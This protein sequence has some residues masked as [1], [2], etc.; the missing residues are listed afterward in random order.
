[1]E[2]VTQPSA[3]P[4]EGWLTVVKTSRARQKIQ[5][6]LK[7]QRREDSIALGRDMLVREL[8]RL[9]KPMTTDRDLVNAAQSFG[10]ESADGLLASLGQGDVSVVSVTQRLHP[11]IRE[12][13]PAKK[14]PLPG[15]RRSRSVPEGSASREWE[16][17]PPGPLLSACPRRADRGRGHPGR[18]LSVHRV[19]CPNVFEDR[20]RRSGEWSCPGTPDT[21][22]RGQ[23]PR[24]GDDR[25]RHAA[26]AARR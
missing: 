13:P 16:P 25:E 7:E 6:W 9:R 8:R 24:F 2:V 22:P 23:A 19:D 15:S 1:V 14:T 10:I 12:E 4:A 20:L 21:R 18:G 26:R 3:H 5:H 11:E 17:D